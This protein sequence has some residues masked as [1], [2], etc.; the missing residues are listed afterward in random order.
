MSSYLLHLLALCIESR[1]Q[2]RLAEQVPQD[3]RTKR[4]KEQPRMTTEEIDPADM[5]YVD[6]GRAATRSLLA[7]HGLDLADWIVIDGTTFVERAGE[8]LARAAF[9]CSCLSRAPAE[10]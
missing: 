7:V 3:G 5:A 4:W 10:A 6:Q 8:L 9:P 2:S 1:W